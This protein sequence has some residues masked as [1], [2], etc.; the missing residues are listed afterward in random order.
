MEIEVNSENCG[1]EIPREHFDAFMA[2]DFQGVVTPTL[3]G[4][5]VVKGTL[6]FAHTPQYRNRFVYFT[7]YGGSRRDAVLEALQ[8]LLHIPRQQEVGVLETVHRLRID[9]ELP[10]EPQMPDDIENED[11]AQ[12]AV[13]LHRTAMKSLS[14]AM[15]VMCL[16][17]VDSFEAEFDGLAVNGVLPYILLED[18][19]ADRVLSTARKLADAIVASG[20]RIGI[21]VEEQADDRLEPSQSRERG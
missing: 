17:G 11:A 2:L 13:D 7:V 1:I 8:D 20:G 3:E 6:S 9:F 21:P 15:D 19:D 5:G 4:A 10:P 14:D 16:D 18:A 12:K